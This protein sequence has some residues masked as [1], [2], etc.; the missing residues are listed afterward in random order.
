MIINDLPL[1]ILDEMTDE[2][3]VEKGTVTYKTNW[4]QVM[5]IWHL[6]RNNLLDNPWFTVNQRTSGA[7]YWEATSGAFLCD[8]W[9]VYN[10]FNGGA[11]WARS[12]HNITL[13]A[14][15]LSYS[16]EERFIQVTQTIPAD[17]IASIL[18]RPIT[19]SHQ[20]G[21]NST[22]M[23]SA[24]N[25]SVNQELCRCAIGNSGYLI[26]GTNKNGTGWF[27]IRAMAGHTVDINS[28]KLEVGSTS[29]L[30]Y[31]GLPNYATELAKCQ[32]FFFML[33]NVGNWQMPVCN[34]WTLSS[35]EARFAVR[36]PSGFYDLPGVVEV[37]TATYTI[38]SGS[39]AGTISSFLI[40]A[41]SSDKQTIIFRVQG[42]GLTQYAPACLKATGTNGTTTG[43][44]FSC[45][46]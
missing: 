2:I 15:E 19:I 25:T 21:S 9:L 43:L 30:H 41:L 17:T 16:S 45:E 1:S 24:V 44:A 3:P 20:N 5:N 10:P 27:I 31:D 34:G 46:I 37:G 7:T 12:G 38:Y 32:R 26:F 23:P 13:N 33:S 42:S 18:G 11:S 29:T 28:V 40:G 36:N 22:I 4:N 6:Y 39:T 14:S 8:R 35:T